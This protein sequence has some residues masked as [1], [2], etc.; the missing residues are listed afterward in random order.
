MTLPKL[1]P[2][3]A[4]ALLLTACEA[5]MGNDATPNAN[6]SAEG[7]AEEGQLS[8]DAPG[9]EMKIDIPE[10][11]ERQAGIDDDSGVIYPN[12]TFSGI[13]VQGGDG[14]AEGE[15]EVELRFASNDAPDRVAA[16]YRDAARSADFSVGSARREAQA[17]V[18][19]GTVRDGGSPFRVRLEPRQGGGTDARVVLADRR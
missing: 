8:I 13:H 2:A 17:I 11:M 10:G 19:A 7:K 18:I 6:A 1:L 12:S 3:V 9:F 5:R 16:W 14:G 15:G 4:A